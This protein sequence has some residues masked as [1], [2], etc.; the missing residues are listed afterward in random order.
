MNS[1]LEKIV[2]GEIWVSNEAYKNL[3]ILCDTFGSRFAGTNEEKM[4]GIF[5]AESF[6]KYGLENVNVETFKLLGWQRNSVKFQLLTPIRIELEAISLAFSP[7]TPQGGVKGNV[8]YLEVGS[9]EDFEKKRDF[10]KG[11]IVLCKNEPYKNERIKQSDRILRAQE[12][13]AIGY[14][15]MNHLPGQLLKTGN[16]RELPSIG[17]SYETGMFLLR[18]LS[19]AKV[20]VNMILN[21]TFNS[22]GNPLFLIKIFLFQKQ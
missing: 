10:I 9:K 2:S 22:I 20:L 16:S 14:I 18:Q 13:G 1:V 19:K 17:I 21:N 4:A 8:V 5:I 6:K 7:P 11:Q 12:Y 3:L 15:L